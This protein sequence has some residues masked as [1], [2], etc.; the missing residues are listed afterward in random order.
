MV[1]KRIISCFSIFDNVFPI[2]TLKRGFGRFTGQRH[3]V[4]V[5]HNKNE[6]EVYAMWKKPT[7]K[8]VAVCAEVTAYAYNTK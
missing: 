7:Y 2:F 8:V 6:R 5:R 3:F 1:A 4:R